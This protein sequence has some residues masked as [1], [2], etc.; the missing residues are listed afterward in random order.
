MI[1]TAVRSFNSWMIVFR[2]AL[3]SSEP[4]ELR[5]KI[6]NLLLRSWRR[7]LIFLSA[8]SNHGSGFDGCGSGGA[9]GSC[10]CF[11][12]CADILVIEMLQMWMMS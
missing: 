3:T 8:C 12:S 5:L 1:L 9:G 10:C 6:K 4:R 11:G 2:E 7:A